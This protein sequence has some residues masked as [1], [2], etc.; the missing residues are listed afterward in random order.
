MRSLWPR[1]IAVSA[2]GVAILIAVLY[3]ATTVDARAPE[4][5]RVALTQ[6][7]PGQE[8]VALTAT[9]IEV[10]FSEPVIAESAQRAFSVEPAVS[11]SFSWSGAVMVFT[12]AQQLPLE[13]TF[14]VELRPGVRDAAGNVASDPAPAFEFSTVG[15][16]E[17]V[18]TQPADGADDAPLDGP[19][20]VAFSRLMD[21]ASV[22]AALDVRPSFPRELRWVGDRLEIVPQLPLAPDQ[23]YEVLVGRRASDSAG[24][25]LASP[26][27][28]SFTT[29]AA[30]LEPVLRLPADEAEG[31]AITTP[32]AVVFDRPLDA[33]TV[34]AD[35]L[36]LVPDAAG[37]V[38]A[39]RA[40]GEP[41]ERPEEAR[42][43]IFRPSG[44][45]PAN[46][47]FSVELGLDV[48]ALDGS[49]LPRTGEWTF[50]TG[51]PLRSLANQLVFLSDRTGVTNLWSMNPD[52]T[53]QRQVSAE[54]NPVRDYAVNPN[55]RSFVVADGR[56]VVRYAADGT[57]RRVLTDPGLIEADPAYAPDGRTVAL[58][59]WDAATGAAH[60]I[61]LRDADGGGPR[62]LRIA[63]DEASP[64]PPASTAETD[65]PAAAAGARAPRFSPDGGALAFVAADGNVGIVELDTGRLLLAPL[66]AASPPA[67]LPDSSA[68]AVSAAREG[69]RAL[70]AP[71]SRDGVARVDAIALR[72][73]SDDMARLE[74]WTVS[75]GDGSPARTAFGRG[76]VR[77]ALAGS[78]QLAFIRSD[79]DGPEAADP[80][81]P[82]GLPRIAASVSGRSE[83][84]GSGAEL[85][86]AWIAF[87]PQ[88][89][90]LAVAGTA[91]SE[92]R[93][94]TGLWLLAGGE[95]VERLSEDGFDPRWLP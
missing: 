79:G 12:P 87:A 83:S 57:E 31:V 85:A 16:P 65:A 75:R 22:E 42:T 32:V 89:D 59:R 15:P 81:A 20:V 14:V 8:R 47:T 60:G 62:P 64:G 30:G 86:G 13:S 71:T 41:A 17:V 33:E 18:D 76:A 78:G 19:I 68:V 82:I 38:L 93:P 51:A 29:V 4:V 91:T 2:V 95:V 9:S 56:R 61:W 55:G 21:T 70:L 43:L 36:R 80:A 73:G 28:F 67:W 49:P 44:A 11:G 66:S 35:A 25:T 54:L 23:R 88:P 74:I 27:R 84:L 53:N 77:P 92:G 46:T 94:L 7:A 40:D 6:P 37:T 69:R 52:G 1:I 72:L 3:V 5:T 50:T 10:V 45:L 39:A 58:A 26:V 63:D 24:V 90:R 34:D 48:R